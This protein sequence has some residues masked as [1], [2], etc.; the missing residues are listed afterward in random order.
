LYKALLVDDD[1]VILNGLQNLIGWDT[2]GIE[3]AGTALNGADALQMMETKFIHILCTDIKMPEMDGIELVRRA[4]QRFSDVKI[5]IL[6]GFDEFGY[7]REAAKYGV[8]DYLLKPVNRDEISATLL[9]TVDRLNQDRTRYRQ[10]RTETNILKENVLLRWVTGG[11]RSGELENK[12]DFLGLKANEG[13]YLAA[14]IVDLNEKDGGEDEF[15]GYPELKTLAITSICRDLIPE[16]EAYIFTNLTGDAVL[17]FHAPEP[18]ETYDRAIERLE[19]CGRNIRRYLNRSVFITVGSAEADQDDVPESYAN[20]YSLQE[21]RMIASAGAVMEYRREKERA[22]KQGGTISLFP[23]KTDRIKTHIWERD[24]TGVL[25]HIDNVFGQLR[26]CPALTPVLVRSVTTQIVFAVI[27]TVGE[28]RGSGRVP[29][30]ADAVLKEVFQLQSIKAMADWVKRVA[31]DMLAPYC[32]SRAGYS[33]VVDK[34]VQ[35]ILGDYGQELSLKSL[36]A[37]YNMN[38]AYLGQ[39]FKSETGAGFSAYLNNVRIAAS[40]RLL[41]ESGLHIDQIAAKTGYAT[42]SYFLFAFKKLTGMSPTEYRRRNRQI[43]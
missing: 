38:P 12:L 36:A 29:I 24:L 8:E 9:H 1:P 19:E 18:G 25:R 10:K 30:R 37:E 42:V 40:Q 41:T 5:V 27:E 17:L 22:D 7:V 43:R 35:K 14:V 15:F 31:E 21:Y 6:S 23:F 20:A 32:S 3:I 11:I 16:D 4:K 26:N 2:L 33:P 13:F 34:C 28:L 39:R